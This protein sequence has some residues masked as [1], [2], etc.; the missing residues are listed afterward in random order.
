MATDSFLPGF[1][2]LDAFTAV[3]A[4]L[5]KSLLANPGVGTTGTV[6]YGARVVSVLL[7]VLCSLP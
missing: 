3:C 5:L 7:L 4:C 6:K 2:S 1:A